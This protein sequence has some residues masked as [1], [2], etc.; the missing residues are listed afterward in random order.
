[1]QPTSKAMLWTGRVMSALPAL[2]LLL[3]GGMKLFK[4]EFVVIRYHGIRL[5][6]KRHR[7]TGHRVDYQHAA[8]PHSPDQNDKAPFC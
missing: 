3:D 6:R 2:F 1:M 4:L 5:C 8:L 7:A